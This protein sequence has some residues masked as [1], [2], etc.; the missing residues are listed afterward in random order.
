[1]SAFVYVL[2]SPPLFSH[3]PGAVWARPERAGETEG[4]LVIFSVPSVASPDSDFQCVDFVIRICWTIIWGHAKW[5]SSKIKIRPNQNLISVEAT[6]KKQEKKWKRYLKIIFQKTLMVN[7][8][9]FDII[10]CQFISTVPSFFVQSPYY[11]FAVSYGCSNRI[12][13][14]CMMII[15][16]WSNKASSVSA[17]FDIS[18]C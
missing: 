13:A 11:K 17:C 6:P 16:Q 12:L 18:V 10:M 15:I 3:F 8:F 5:T 4:Q 14:A 9:K 7:F 2:F 1:M